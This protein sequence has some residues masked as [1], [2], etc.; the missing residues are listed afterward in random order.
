MHFAVRRALPDAGKSII[1]GFNS[2][3]RGFIA[4]RTYHKLLRMR[5]GISADI[6]RTVTAARVRTGK[7][8]RG[9]YT[10]DKSAYTLFLRSPGNVQAEAHGQQVAIR[11][12]VYIYSDWASV[13]NRYKAED[14]RAPQCRMVD[15]QHL[16]L[17][18]VGIMVFELV[19]AAVILAGAPAL[20]HAQSAL[21]TYQLS[22]VR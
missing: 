18:V 17:Q 11:C 16:Q 6:A 3:L 9:H 22:V 7:R 12:S 8:S 2:Q 13:P 5:P 19:L 1:K 14:Q 20:A 21:G 4:D 15:G 10:A